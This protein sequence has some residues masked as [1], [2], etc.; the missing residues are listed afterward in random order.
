MS[1]P[2]LSVN[3]SKGDG[4][5]RVQQYSYYDPKT[6]PKTPYNYLWYL[7]VSWKTN[8]H[9]NYTQWVTTSVGISNKLLP[10]AAAFLN[11]KR[12]TYARVLY[13]DSVWKEIRKNFDRPNYYNETFRAAALTDTYSF[14]KNG[15]LSWKRLL[16]LLKYLKVD[17]HELPWTYGVEIFEDLLGRLKFSSSAFDKLKKLITDV[18]ADR[19]VYVGSYA[20]YY[21]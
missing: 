2:I 16:N 18:V 20:W 19:G 7:P 6:L 15:G 17:N 8:Y 10:G 11:H 21:A 12:E 1:Y 4:Y 14:V 13:S 5:V 3:Y 9:Y